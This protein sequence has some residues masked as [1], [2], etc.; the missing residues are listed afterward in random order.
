MI[1]EAYNQYG[2]GTVCKV[3]ANTV[4]EN[5]LLGEIVKYDGSS[6]MYVRVLQDYRS[7]S[8]LEDRTIQVDAKNISIEI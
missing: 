5:Y 2:I 3:R 7:P 8:A 4:P 6:G 1:T